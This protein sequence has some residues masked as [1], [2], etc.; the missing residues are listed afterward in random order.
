MSENIAYAANGAKP[1]TDPDCFTE[2]TLPIPTPDVDDVVVQL[3]ATALNPI[4]TKRRAALPAQTEPVIFGYD[5]V[6]IV[7]A[8]G[9][10]VTAF[11]VGQR[12]LYSGT[13]KRP[14][15][16][17]HYQSVPAALV[18]NAP[19]AAPAADLA[20]LPLVGLTAWELLF[21][22]MGFTP[23]ADANSGQSVLVINGAGGVGSMLTQL[24]HWA[25]LT[26]YATASPQHFDWLLAHGVDHP[27]DYHADI[28]Q[29]VQAHTQFVDG[30][31]I[32]YA[33]AP[34]IQ[35]A[36]T[37]IAPLGHV[38]TI[39]T[40]TDPLDLAALKPKAASFDQEYMFTKSD[41][42]VQVASTRQILTQLANLYQAGQL[43]ASVTQTWPLTL[44]NLLTAT[45]Q[46]EAGHTHGKLC[47]LMEA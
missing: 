14:G 35:A 2:I 12:V 1:A 41:F 21:E 34:Y 18:A 46:L 43:T 8:V 36:A 5:G 11:K 16:Y 40:P 30:V 33:P 27:L 24:A 45:Q 22:K 10:D 31:A 47:L 42:G 6:G 9:R 37:L 32:L 28:V 15:S 7:S 38:A 13:T 17:Q 26:V 4:D 39:V 25:G 23:Q 44:A 29:A 3:E 20:A 19:A